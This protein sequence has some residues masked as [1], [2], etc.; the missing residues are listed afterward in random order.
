[1][2]VSRIL[3]PLDGSRLAEAI[4]PVAASFA[5]KLGATLVLLHVLEQEPPQDVHGESHLARADDAAAYLEQRA[6][7]LRRAGVVVEVDVH[8]RPVGNVAA[9]IDRHAH[10]H[11][12]DLI[13]MCAHGRTNPLDRL[14]GSIAE[15]ILRGGSAP[16]L[17][18]TVQEPS[19][20]PFALRKL[21]VPIDFEHDLQEALAVVRMLAA[22]YDAPVQLLSVREPGPATAARLLPGTTA[23]AEQFALDELHRRIDELAA[24]LR[25]EG[26]AVAGAEVSDR[27]PSAAILSAV[28]SGSLVVLVTDAHGGP[29]TWFDPP[30]TQQL[31]S[32]PDLTL[33][34]I[35]EM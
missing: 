17:L 11:A 13:A 19:D 14:L 33:L 15:R 4:L 22:A 28:E 24:A 18:R 9:A 7:A 27:R 30:T 8:D 16:I 3:V 35:K 5:G 26:V 21:L 6:Q 31:L 23:L 1:M 12:A 29:G 10:E 20:Q 34:L 2:Q 25:A 32:H